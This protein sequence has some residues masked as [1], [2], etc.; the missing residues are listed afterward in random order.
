M[1]WIK[2]TPTIAIFCFLFLSTILWSVRERECVK[3]RERKREFNEGHGELR[4]RLIYIVYTSIFM[5]K[6]YVMKC[7]DVS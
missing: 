5:V 4:S 2:I 6:M 1:S 7:N 3:E